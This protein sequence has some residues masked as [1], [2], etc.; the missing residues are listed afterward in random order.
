MYTFA[1]QTTRLTKT[2]YS[3][4]GKANVYPTTLSQHLLYTKERPDPQKRVKPKDLF[5]NSTARIARTVLSPY[6]PTVVTLG[7]YEREVYTGYD[8][9]QLVD[10]SPFTSLNPSWTSIENKVRS[11]LR[12][13]YANFAQALAEYRQTADLFSSATRDFVRISRGLLRRD[14]S[15]LLPRSKWSKATSGQWLK[16]QYGVLPLMSDVH[17]AVNTLYARTQ[18]PIYQTGRV[19]SSEY[20]SKQKTMDVRLFNRLAGTALLRS[21]SKCESRIKYRVMFSN[22]PASTLSRLGLS[23]P[24]VLAWELIPFSFVVDWFFNIGDC[25]QSLDT[26]NQITSLEVIRARKTIS[27]VSAAPKSGSWSGSGNRNEIVYN[28]QAPAGLSL[29]VRPEYSP[30]PSWTKLSIAMALLVQLRG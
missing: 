10:M 22:E 20:E 16:Y 1:H 18:L 3:P 12:S 5:G 27:I 11:K 24:A 7:S 15:V 28:R 14:P 17:G 23:N 26:C 6:C 19:S 9:G 13:D 25:L 29:I 8:V 4:S 21:E 30:S 2:V